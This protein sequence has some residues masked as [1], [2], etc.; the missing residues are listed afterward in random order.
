MWANNLLLTKDAD[1][2]SLQVHLKLALFNLYQEKLI[3]LVHL[4]FLGNFFR[5]RMAQCLGPLTTEVS[6]A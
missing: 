1:M 5:A 3:V 4:P 6:V 2:I